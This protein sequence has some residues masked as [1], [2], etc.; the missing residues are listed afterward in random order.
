MRRTLSNLAA[1]LSLVFFAAM[2]VVWMESYWANTY[3][4]WVHGGVYRIACVEHGALVIGWGPADSTNSLLFYHREGHGNPYR[5]LIR[6]WQFAGFGYSHYPKAIN[7]RFSL[8]PQVRLY[9]LFP[10]WA[11]TA[12]WL[13]L[14]TW[15][16]F[17]RIKRSSR[18]RCPSCS[19]SLTGNTSSV[20]PECGTA[21]AEKAKQ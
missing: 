13:V 17:Y 2:V 18:G 15:R 11:M 21:T 1:A 14:P 5:N 4:R 16:L 7:V 8:H 20:C 9:L 19:Y 12:L 10:L 6:N 3:A